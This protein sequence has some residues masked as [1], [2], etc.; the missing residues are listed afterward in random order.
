MNLTLVILFTAISF[1]IYVYSSF[2]SR[3]MK[4]EYARWGYSDQRKIVGFLQLLG[5]LGL[6]IGIKIDI[7]LILT[8]FCFILMMNMAIFIRIK[9]KDNIVDILPAIT[10]LFLNILI[11]YNS[12]T[13]YVL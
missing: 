5:G 8:S 2:V 3:R 6:L 11:L 9:I 13:H 4:S 12:I 10:Y 7:L 1:I